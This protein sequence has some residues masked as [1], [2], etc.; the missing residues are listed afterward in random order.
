MA[1]TNSNTLPGIIGQ[2]Y[3]DRR[4]GEFGTLVSR[5][6]KCKTMEYQREDGTTFVRSYSHFRSY[7]RKKAEASAEVIKEEAY[8]EA[9]LTSVEVSEEDAK[10]MEKNAKRKAKAE[11]K[12][13][14]EVEPKQRK[15]IAP[16]IKS[17]RYAELCKIIDDFV[18]SFGSVHICNKHRDYKNSCLLKVR[19]KGLATFYSRPKKNTVYILS[20]PQF[21]EG[22][23]HTVELTDVKHHEGNKST[24]NRTESYVIAIS[25]LKN[26]LEDLRELIVEV[27]A[28]E[29]K[30]SED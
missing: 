28:Y 22:I 18:D 26:Y 2:V 11:E 27:I 23:S 9:E 21:I 5:D 4:N 24:K 25:D 6:T 8:A 1:N 15:V 29:K 30:E 16:E 17:D 19:G 7:M 12:A 10:K 14:K 3:E 13:K 20:V